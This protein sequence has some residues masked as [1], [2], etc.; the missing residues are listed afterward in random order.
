MVPP[1]NLG[2]DLA[3]KPVNETIYRGMIGSLMYLTA[4]RPDIQFSTYYDSCN[5]D[6]KSTSGA[7]QLLGGKLVCCSAKKQQ[8]VPMSFAEAEEFWYTAISF[9]PC[10]PKDDYE[11]HPL[12]E[13]K[14]KFTL[15]NGQ[16]QL[17]SEVVKAELAKITMNEALIQKN[18]VLKTS[19]HAAWRILLT[20]V[21]RFLGGNY[22]S[23]EQLN[24]IQQLLAY[25][26]LTRTKVD[27]GEIIYSD[28]VTRTKNL[29]FGS[30]P[31]ILTQ[32]NFTKDPSKIIPIELTVSMIVVNNLESAVT[33]L[34]CLEMKK[35][36]KKNSQTVSQP[37]LKTQGPEA[38]G[39]LP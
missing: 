13:F 9:Y 30:L 2:P 8:S 17:C 11:A 20:F 18:H 24:S 14:I 5:M 6:R 7:C 16:R 21:V 25:C 27:I 23:T 33:P 10:P 1:N 4:T 38:F 3:S 12:K 26:L 37:K 36:K 32:S 28:L 39:A 19:F 34:P 31:N 35:N 29:G 15:M 22:S